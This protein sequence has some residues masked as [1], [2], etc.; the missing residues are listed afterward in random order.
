MYMNQFTGELYISIFH[1]VRT[2][3]SDMI[4]FPQCRTWKML[5]VRREER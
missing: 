1:A 3:I 2:I 4:H 5:N